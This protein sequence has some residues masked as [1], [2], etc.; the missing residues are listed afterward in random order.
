[1]RWVVVVIF[2]LFVGCPGD[3]EDYQQ[4]PMSWDEWKKIGDRR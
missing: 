2:V 4:V 1:M 3:G